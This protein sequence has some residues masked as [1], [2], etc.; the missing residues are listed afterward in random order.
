[1]KSSCADDGVT[2][3]AKR[4]PAKPADVKFFHI[5]VPPREHI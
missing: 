5:L 4:A 2:A 3:I 1:M